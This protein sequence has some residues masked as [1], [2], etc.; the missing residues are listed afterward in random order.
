MVTGS[1][2]PQ[3]HRTL[4]VPDAPLDAANQS[5]ADA[6]RASFSVL[7]GIMIILIV[8]FTFSGLKCVEEHQKAVV[9]R[10]GKLKSQ[11]VRGPGLSPAWPYPVDETLR[12]GVRAEVL[13]FEEIHTA[14]GE[15][16]FGGLHPARDG[17]LLTAD[18]GLAHVRWSVVYRV[19]DLA[20]FVG[21]VSDANDETSKELIQTLLEH[22]AVRAAAQFTAAE[23]SQSRTDALA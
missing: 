6:L 23:I 3:P 18:K 21:N 16:R 15:S 7:K 10:F 1:P 17:A 9:L 2:D 5:L 12:V 13:R 20:A 19:E 4:N 14:A 11:D 8:L 22:A